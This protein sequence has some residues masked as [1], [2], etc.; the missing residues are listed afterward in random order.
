MQRIL[1]DTHEFLVEYLNNGKL[2]TRVAAK[3][4]YKNFHNLITDARTSGL[5]VALSEK[6]FD[7]A[8]GTLEGFI[9]YFCGFGLVI[10]D[11][12]GF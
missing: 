1:T 5:I 8:W 7:N 12:N 6:D 2:L 10:M 4:A 3:L 9:T 11:T